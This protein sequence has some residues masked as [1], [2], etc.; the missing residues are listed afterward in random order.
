MPKA[1]P[2]LTPQQQVH[3][4]KDRGV[5]FR[6]MNEDA[7][8]SYLSRNN[9][10]F[11][12]RS[13]RINFAKHTSGINEGKYV[14]LD[15]AMLV[16]LAIIDMH[17]RDEM[18]KLTLDIEH[19]SKVQL[20]QEIEQQDEDGYS[21]VEDFAKDQAQNGHPLKMDY[22]QG[23]KS[24]Y[25]G[26]LIKARPD[27]DFPVWEFIEVI[28]FGRFVHFYQFCAERFADSKMRNSCYMLQSV[29]TLGMGV[30]TTA[31]S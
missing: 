4:L 30:P 11:R 16:D 10:Y 18:L 29:K 17:L 21:I 20:L 22:S 14:N 26:A 9:T 31:V 7:A 8:V 25:I 23:L 3:Q 6:I 19:F 13:Y 1:K 12:I 27:R 2:W 5:T 24:A 28:P 15:F